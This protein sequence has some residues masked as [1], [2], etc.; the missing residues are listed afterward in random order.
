MSSATLIFDGETHQYRLGQQRL[1]SV[2]QVIASTGLIHSEWFSEAAAWRGSVVHRCCELD[3]L[4][5]LREESVD[6]GAAEYLTGWRSF[7]KAVGFTATMVEAPLHHW[8]L[9][10]AGT[11]DR[12]GIL[13]DGSRVVIDIKTGVAAAWHGLQLAAY[14]HLA[15][16]QPRHMRRFTVRLNNAGSYSATEYTTSAL[17]ADW[18]AFQGALALNN[19]RMI[20][21]I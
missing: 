10:Y 9:R 14:A 5:L 12:I 11:P 21:G 16:Q 3:D 19:W 13:R 4:G 8:A 15:S 6:P 17:S 1:P 7:K 18:A 20:N 2:T